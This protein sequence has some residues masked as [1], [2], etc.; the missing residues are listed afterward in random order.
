M[1]TE[2]QYYDENVFPS[3]VLGQTA[4]N[5]NSALRGQLPPD[6]VDFLRNQSAEGAVAAGMPG[7]S[8][9]QG[10]LP[11]YSS[12]RTLGL[13]SLGQMNNA[14]KLASKFFISPLQASEMDQRQQALDEQIR[15]QQANAWNNQGPFT[16][17][18]NT[19]RMAPVTPT[20][21]TTPVG[22]TPVPGQN[23]STWP[24]ATSPWESYTPA[25]GDWTSL[26]GWGSGIPTSASYDPFAGYEEGANWAGVPSTGSDWFDESNWG[27]DNSLGNLEDWGWDMSFGA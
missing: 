11:N 20:G 6:V 21:R 9:Y 17:P 16:P 25:T 23:A 22:Y 13:T 7:A 10:S 15:Q 3:Y 18:V 27:Y 24:G 8:N 26:T 2:S 12:L 19:G 4:S 14:E 5:L 1:A